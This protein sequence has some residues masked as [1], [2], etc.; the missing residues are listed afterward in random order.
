MGD[1]NAKQQILSFI[2]EA[3]RLQPWPGTNVFF[4][5]DYDS[6]YAEGCLR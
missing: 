5:I 2:V 1:L 6:V 3:A 4:M